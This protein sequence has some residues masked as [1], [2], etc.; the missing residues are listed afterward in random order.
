MARTRPGNVITADVGG[1]SF[2]VGLVVDGD[3]RFATDR[4]SNGYTRAPGRRR[5]VHRHRWRQHRVDRRRPG[6][7]A[8]RTRERRVAPGPACYGRGGDRPTVTDAAS[9]SAMSPAQRSLV[10]D[11]DARDGVAARHRGADWESDLMTAAHRVFDVATAQMTDLVRR[12][13]VQCGHDPAGSR[14]TRTVAH[15]PIRRPVRPGWVRRS[16]R[17][18]SR[19]GVLGP[20]RGDADVRVRHERSSRPACSPLGDQADEVLREFEAALDGRRVMATRPARAR[21][22]SFGLRYLRQLN[23]LD[24]G[25]DERR[26]RGV[27]RLRRVP[28]A[29]RPPGGRGHLDDWH[30]HRDRAVTVVAIRCLPARHVLAAPDADPDLAAN[31]ALG[32]A[33]GNA[34]SGARLGAPGCRG[35]DRRA[36]V[37]RIAADD[38]RDARRSGGDHRHRRKPHCGGAVRRWGCATRGSRGGATRSCSRSSGTGSTASTR[39]PP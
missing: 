35:A 1:T 27:P 34:T 31:A 19:S 32:S 13:T 12:T 28:A 24:V 20:R 38:R 25:V 3:V 6:R 18:A 5:H 22:A 10:L 29:V 8:G 17:T 4:R 23:A 15:G 2:D 33:G 39:T 26:S 30:A 21:Q 36:G 9:C 14:S 11:D 16:G 7:A 37:R